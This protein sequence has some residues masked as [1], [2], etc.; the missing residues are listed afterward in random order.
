MVEYSERIE[1]LAIQLLNEVVSIISF[2]KGGGNSSYFKPLAKWFLRD[3]GCSETDFVLCL[4][5]LKTYHIHLYNKLDIPKKWDGCAH[6]EFPH[7]FLKSDVVQLEAIHPIGKL[8]LDGKK[9]MG[10]YDEGDIFTA[11]A[12]MAGWLIR[13]RWAVKREDNV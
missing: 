10:P 8:D 9:T 6:L 3:L 7:L 5:F 12:E 2:G 11:S 1:R 13:R 4:D